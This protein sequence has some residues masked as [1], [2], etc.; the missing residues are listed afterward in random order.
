MELIEEFLDESCGFLKLR[1]K[2]KIIN[3]AVKRLEAD[4][5]VI[6]PNLK[7]QE[8]GELIEQMIPNFDVY[9]PNDLEIKILI[10]EMFVKMKKYN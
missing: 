1:Q 4:F 5:I 2:H 9:S 6:E 8:F 7:S 3:D 10:Q